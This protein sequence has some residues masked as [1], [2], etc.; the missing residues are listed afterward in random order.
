MEYSADAIAAGQAYLEHFGI[1][2]MK[3]GIRR[4][5]KQL[6]AARGVKPW[7]EDSSESQENEKASD[8]RVR[9]SKLSK[10]KIHTMSNDELRDY[11]TRLQL[12]N[13]LIAAQRQYRQLTE[14]QKKQKEH[15]ARKAIIGLGSSVAT[16]IAREYLT[17]AGKIK[18]N[19]YLNRHGKSQ[20]TVKIKNDK[21]KDKDKDNN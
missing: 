14:P 8:D 3:W 17:Q 5:R 10:R 16:N 18:I 6:Q 15:R 21:D 11:T 20:F 9:A 19:D 4:T 2:G 13:Q 7:E 1:K 12:E